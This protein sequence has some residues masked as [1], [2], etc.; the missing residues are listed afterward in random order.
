MSIRDYRSLTVAARKTLTQMMK[1]ILLTLAVV[2][3]VACSAT[4][5]SF[6]ASLT[7]RVTD[8]SGA[9][10]ARA[11]VEVTNTA[12]G[13]TTTA[14][15]NEAGIY[16]APGLPPGTYQVTVEHPGFKKLVQ[17]GIKLELD[18]KARLDLTLE[19][20]VVSESVDVTT[21]APV[22][23]SESGAKGQ[24]IDNHEILDLPLNGRDFNELAYLTPGVVDL[25]EG[26]SN[27][28][29]TAINGGRA[30]GVNYLVDG[31]TNRSVSNGSAV[32]Q[33]SVD[34]VQ[35]FKVQT[36]AYAADY[37]TV[38]S[39]V[40]N[41]ALKSGT[42]QVHGTIYEFSR[43]SAMDARNFFDTTKSDMSRYQFGG[44]IGGPIVIPGKYNGRDR[45]FFFGSFEGLESETGDARL[46]RV[47]TDSERAGDFSSLLQGSRKT[48]LRDPALSGTC[49][50]TSQAACFPGNIIPASRF[51]PI[52]VMLLKLV[53]VANR[54]GVNNFQTS[55][56]AT[57]SKKDFILKFD[58]RV[59][60]RVNLALSY[61][62]G[63]GSSTSPYGASNL[64]GFGLAGK[65]RTKLAGI[66]SSQ[67]LRTTVV[68]DLRL[69]FSRMAGTS[70]W[71]RRDDP[72]LMDAVQAMSIS[73]DPT[74][75]GLPRISM[76]G[77]D[78]IGHHAS[79]PSDIPVTNYQ[80]FDALSIFRG[81]H[82]LRVGADIIYTQ[83]YQ[84]Y[85]NNARGSLSVLGRVT[86]GTATP[87]PMADFL[88]GLPDSGSVLLDPRRNYLTY[89]TEAMFIQDD[90]KITPTLTL[91]LGLRYDLLFPPV[92]KYNKLSSFVPEL[93]RIVVAGDPALPR[94]LVQ[95]NKA[96]FAPRGGF[97]WRPWNSSVWVVRGGYGIFYTGTAQNSIRILA[98]NNTPYSN[99]QNFS[100]STT[101]PLAYTFSN[102]FPS[103]G[104]GVT[105]T[106]IP[107]GVAVYA[108]PAYMESYNF[109]VERRIGAS[110]VAEVSYAGSHGVHLPRK[111]DVNQQIRLSP[112]QIVRPFPQYNGAIQ[113]V[114]FGSSSSYNALQT[115]LRRSFRNGVGFRANFVWSKALDECSGVTGTGSECVAQDSYNLSLERG[116]SGYNRPRAFTLDFSY[117][118]PFARGKRFLG[119]WQL[120]GIVKLYD[121]QPFTPTISSYSF[122]QGGASRPDAIGSGKLDNPTVDRWFNVADFVAVP[123]GS[124]RFG[125]AGRNILDGPPLKQIDLSGMKIFTL[126]NEQKL[127]F[128][129]E[130]FN[131]P[132]VANFYLPVATVDSTNAGT[133]TQ[134][135]P[136]RSIQ[137]GLKY[138]F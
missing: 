36:S 114:S 42:N 69:S 46:S 98:A 93:K 130:L 5:Q 43:N 135:R 24:V 73:K 48:Y 108:G 117:Q 92:E 128:R 37:G 52:A 118:L 9:V 113:Y 47:P 23:N 127:Q 79:Y 131:A 134:A 44:T 65:S 89:K 62:S 75:A 25:P 26:L 67:M 110:L 12:T 61:V 122:A 82:S 70:D 103:Y 120:N 133:I 45:S 32:T 60:D 55:Q 41:V 74:Y 54:T 14:L 51:N 107:N 121:G 20:G 34:A 105:V 28:G 136:G 56:V 29:V 96:D 83:Y 13:R 94:S 11:R 27:S 84:Y 72:D 58:Q 33:P 39:G 53:P 86:G 115:S 50:A 97:A 129:V 64:P 49:D 21:E 125:T 59:N 31:L 126:P 18:Q 102:P 22:L 40:I 99:T 63:N 87:V 35:E 10:T 30:D 1:R 123:N 132:N 111:Y 17:H 77:Y 3:T 38:G 78:S 124:F 101:N 15:S 109:T 112:T 85:P 116:R 7:G 71:E 138:L 88:L 95:L 76:T 119:G 68:N 81:R 137:L 91:N 6:E 4:A 106:T 16:T 80:L 8:A 2:L 66:R 104:T 19:V 57:S 90:F 100:R